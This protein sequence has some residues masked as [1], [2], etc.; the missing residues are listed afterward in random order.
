MH[1]YNNYSDNIIMQYAEI[2]DDKLGT[3]I[4]LKTINKCLKE[5]YI[6]FLR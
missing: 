1:N 6:V 4:T 2:V 5:E 3:K